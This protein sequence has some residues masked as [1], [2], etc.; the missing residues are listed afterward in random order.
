MIIAVDIDGILT[1]EK[2]G[3]DYEN[4]TPNPIARTF[5]FQEIKKGNSI[6]YYTARPEMDRA[7]T[8]RWLEKHGFPNAP[9][10]MG[11]PQADFYV[12]D[13]AVRGFDEI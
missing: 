3:H 10:F 6:L 13:K 7:V 9:L 8:I 1:L 4:R 12:D 11:K 5:L 2:D